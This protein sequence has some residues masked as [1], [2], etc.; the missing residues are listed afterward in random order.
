MGAFLGELPERSCGFDH[1][2]IV[3]ISSQK[4][5]P[6]RVSCSLLKVKDTS[7]LEYALR[8]NVFTPNIFNCFFISGLATD[9]RN[10]LILLSKLDN[11]GCCSA[12]VIFHYMFDRDPYSFARFCPFCRH[13]FDLISVLEV[14]CFA[15]APEGLLLLSRSFSLSF[16]VMHE[17]CYLSALPTRWLAQR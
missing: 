2:P 9:P 15:N 7:F 4:Q 1:E 17:S 8:V 5:N 6:T 13:H 16:P 3:L 10:H 11:L 12:L 14:L